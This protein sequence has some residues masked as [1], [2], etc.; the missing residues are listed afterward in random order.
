[1]GNPLPA[2]PDSRV[3]LFD[4]EV[5]GGQSL[6]Q[7]EHAMALIRAWWP[8]YQME[9]RTFDG[10]QALTLAALMLLLIYILFRKEKNRQ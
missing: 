3:L 10:P 1:M 5:E 6:T 7:A 9:M 8:R 2:H 4:L